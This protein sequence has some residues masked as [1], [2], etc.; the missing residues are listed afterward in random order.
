MRRFLIPGVVVV[1]ALAAAGVWWSRPEPA[2]D[3]AYVRGR[4]IS[5][6]NRLAQV[7]EPVA[8]LQF[9][10]IVDVL[11]RR[12]ENVRIR[13]AAGDVGWVAARHLMEPALWEKSREL[14]GRARAMSVQARGRTKVLSNLRAEPGR[15]A[16]RILQ[17]SA[18]VAVEVVARAVAEWKPDEEESP[19]P[20][21]PAPKK[22]SGPRREDWVLVRANDPD[23]GE[24]AGW[25]LA[26]FLEP[27]LPAPLRDLGAGLRWVA[28]FELDRI[29]D[30]Q[31]GE[32]A[33]F[34]GVAATGP[35]GGPCDFTTLRVY[36]WNPNRSRYETAYVESFLC[37]RLPVLVTPG[38]GET[39][40]SFNNI[41]RRGQ[42]QR[43]YRFRQ[44]IV[45]RMRGR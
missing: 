28:W 23:A 3:Q 20:G 25:V 16:P 40:F 21:A 34:L 39:A 45:R 12:G 14:A 10:Q 4:N 37:G 38:R 43:D 35:E 36:T 41:G 32:R 1:V 19:R 15:E 26:R 9:G 44:N 22:E 17:L 29:P 6:W 31:F 8:A 13:T 24:V 33:Q 5:A 2:L 27:D 7:R 30:E 42:E 18:G 11:E